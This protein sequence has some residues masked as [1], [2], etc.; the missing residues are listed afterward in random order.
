[1]SNVPSGFFQKFFQ[2]ADEAAQL[3][4]DGKLPLDDAV[5]QLEDSAQAS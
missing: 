1:M 2:M 4:I 3:I 5:K